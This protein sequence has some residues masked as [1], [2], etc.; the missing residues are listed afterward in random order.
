MST[1]TRPA[2]IAVVDD[3]RFDQHRSNEPHPE[4]PE[5]LA[6]ARSGLA[7]ALP[8][9]C[10]VDLVP[11]LASEI[12][13]RRVHHPGYLADLAH[14]LA[15]GSGRLDPDT[16]FGRGSA[17][18]AWLAAGGAAQLARH[19]WS[20]ATRRGLALLRPPGHHARPG[21]A[22]GFCLLNNVA[23]AATAALDGG[24]RPR[25]DRRLGRTPRQ[26]H[27]GVLPE[28]RSGAVHLVRIRPPFSPAPGCRRG[29]ARARAR[30]ETCNI[31]LPPGTGPEAY[32]EA[33]RRLVLPLLDAHR[34]DLLLVSAGFDAHA[35]DPLASLELDDA[36]FGAM[37]TA[38]VDQAEAVGHGRVGL[39]LEGGYDLAAIEASTAA[40]ARALLGERTALPAE[41]LRD[42]ERQAIDRSVAA[43]TPAWPGLD[44]A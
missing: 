28:G 22:M 5:R 36:I 14:A 11:S 18:A 9:A 15:T 43:L 1:L 42:A 16:Y 17:E 27:R 7:L 21:A 6:A 26:R 20:G 40:V 37:T 34:A 33:F 8:P 19:L 10:R 25:G 23:V 32:G 35:R 38:L 4:R 2:A 12:D 41:R 29:S 24:G 31:A 39:V 13:L 3:A 44:L 30:A